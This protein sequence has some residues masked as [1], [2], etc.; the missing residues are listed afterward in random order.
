MQRAIK[1]LDIVLEGID[2]MYLPVIKSWRLN[3]RHYGGL[4]GLDKVQTVSKYG[5]EQVQ[6]WRRSYNVPPPELTPENE[7]VK[8]IDRRYNGV[9]KE[10]IP[11]CES[12]ELTE[13]RTLPLWEDEIFPLLKAGKKVLIVAHGNSIR[14]LVFNELYIG[15]KIG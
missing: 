5:E 8:C 4:Q 9:S 10:L 11:K 2:E 13:K 3:E 14:G 15:E 7:I 6:I 1:T 12:L